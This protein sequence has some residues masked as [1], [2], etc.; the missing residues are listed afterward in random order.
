MVL[1][2]CSFI[3]LQKL[4]CASISPGVNTFPFTGNAHLVFML[5]KLF[6]IICLCWIF[7]SIS[8]LQRPTEIIIP[9]RPVAYP[10]KKPSREVRT[11]LISV[12]E[13]LSC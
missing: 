2:L 11:V 9:A 4:R 6:L 5:I 7:S 10:A 1:Q 13:L 12:A 8:K 3:A